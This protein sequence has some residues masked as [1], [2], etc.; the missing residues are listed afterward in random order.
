VVK[1]GISKKMMTMIIST[2][3]FASPVMQ[4]VSP[5]M[6]WHV[7]QTVIG[8]FCAS[9]AFANVAFMVIHQHELPVDRMKVFWAISMTVLCIGFTCWRLPVCVTV[10]LD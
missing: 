4:W 2:D 8:K 5:P 1:I 7:R 3:E 9:L 10:P 6:L